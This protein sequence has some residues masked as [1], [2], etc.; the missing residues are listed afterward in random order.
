MKPTVSLSRTSVVSSSRRR[1]VVVSRVS[2]SRFPV[3][4]PAPVRAF[5]RVLFPALVYPTRAT[6]GTSF[7]CRCRRWVLRTRRTSSSSSRSF[8][9]FRRMCRRSVSS[10]VSPGPRVPMGL[11]PPE[12][13]WRTRWVHMPVSRGRRY[14]YW[15]SSTWSRP[16]RVRARPAKMSRIRP[17]R[18][19]TLVSRLSERT[20]IWLGLSSLSN[21]TRSQFSAFTRSFTS[22][23]L[24]LPMK[25]PGS[26]ASRFWRAQATASPPAVSSRASSSAMLV[27]LLRSAGSM[28]AASS[29]TRTARSRLFPG[30]FVILSM[31]IPPIQKRTEKTPR[32]A[33]GAAQGS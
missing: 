29:P 22:C 26:G 12:A 20:R 24:P 30:S 16:S 13:V 31:V 33:Q 19:K 2:K 27:S 7:F 9:I 11:L 15:A 3:W 6:V 10:W 28:L 23:T 18:S 4:M 5:R 14:W 17:L 25:L 32:K 8:W 1:R 21:T